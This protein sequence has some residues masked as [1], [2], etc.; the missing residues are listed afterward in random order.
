MKK[1]ALSKVKADPATGRRRQH[2][3]DPRG[4]TGE[5]FMVRGDDPLTMASELAGQVR[6]D[7]M[8]G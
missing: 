4:R 6:I 1:A 3:R 2:G 7:L 5:M 8:D